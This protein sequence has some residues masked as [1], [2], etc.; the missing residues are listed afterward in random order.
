MLLDKKGIKCPIQAVI[1]VHKPYV[2][3]DN[4]MF[5]VALVTV[6]VGKP[7]FN[8]QVIEGEIFHFS[9]LKLS[10]ASIMGL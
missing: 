8:I 1:T 5:T 3:N 2:S 4:N 10:I 6:E 7:Q 9:S